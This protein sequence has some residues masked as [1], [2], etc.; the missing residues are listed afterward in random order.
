MKKS[1]EKPKRKRLC[2]GTSRRDV[3]C[4]HAAQRRCSSCGLWLCRLHFPDPEWHS[5]APDQGDS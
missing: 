1:S 4:D 5:C 2:Q 3:P